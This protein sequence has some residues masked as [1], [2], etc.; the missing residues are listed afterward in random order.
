MRALAS[1]ALRAAWSTGF[2]PAVEVRLP[3]P[4]ARTL[5]LPLPP[6]EPVVI[7][8]LRAALAHTDFTAESVA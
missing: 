4:L 7:R 8:T 5:P 1:A 6:T 2:L 3:L